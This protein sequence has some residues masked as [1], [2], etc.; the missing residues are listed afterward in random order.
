MAADGL[1]MLIIGLLALAFFLG[2]LFE[3]RAAEEGVEDSAG[4]TFLADLSPEYAAAR[5]RKRVMP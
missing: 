2:I 3:S 1:S 5:L 4:T